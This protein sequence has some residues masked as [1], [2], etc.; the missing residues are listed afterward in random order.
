MHGPP[1]WLA[2]WEFR[3][4]VFH[5]VSGARL[6]HLICRVSHHDN[7]RFRDWAGASSSYGPAQMRPWIASSTDHRALVGTRLAALPYCFNAH[8]PF[9]SDSLTRERSTSGTKR[10]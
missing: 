8:D 3:A 4:A 10:L 2:K 5:G 9:R 7:L 1:N 6:S